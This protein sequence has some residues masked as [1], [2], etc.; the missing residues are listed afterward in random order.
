MA[1]AVASTMSII[2]MDVSR[3]SW[4]HKSEN[5]PSPSLHKYLLAHV[6]LRMCSEGNLGEKTDGS[7]NVPCVLGFSSLTP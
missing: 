1:D 6:S 4:V 7:H 3:P 2:C 5:A